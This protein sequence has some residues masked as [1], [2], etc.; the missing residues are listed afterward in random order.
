MT[1]QNIIVNTRS[2]R[3]VEIEE[4]GVTVFSGSVADNSTERS[5]HDFIRGVYEAGIRTGIAVSA[6]KAKESA[7]RGYPEEK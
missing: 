7:D 5:W 1:M 2:E 4:N 6:A 3:D